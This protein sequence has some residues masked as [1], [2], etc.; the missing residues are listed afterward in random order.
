MKYNH[1]SNCHI[2]SNYRKKLVYLLVEMVM[3]REKEEM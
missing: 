1:N 3:I 2:I